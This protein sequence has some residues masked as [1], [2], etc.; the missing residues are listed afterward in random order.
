MD[1]VSDNVPEDY[2]MEEVLESFEELDL[3]RDNVIDWK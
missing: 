1:P 2:T 3:N